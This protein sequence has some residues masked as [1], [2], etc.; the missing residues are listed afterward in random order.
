MTTIKE[1]LHEK[2]KTTEDHIKQ[3]QREGTQGIRYIAMM[4]DIPFLVLGLLSDVGWMIHLIAGI[5]YLSGNGFHHV[6]DYM[7]LIALA[8]VMFGVA[9]IIYL[10]RI[11]EKEIATRRQRNLGFGMTFLS[12]ISGS[13]RR[14]TS[15]RDVYWRFIRACVDSNWRLFE[16]RCGTADLSLVQEGDFLRSKITS[17]FAPLLTNQPY[18]TIMCDVYRTI[19]ITQTISGR[20]DTD[21]GSEE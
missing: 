21:Y 15:D 16:L 8:A 6:L 19:Y 5:I 7:A 10:N 3:L 12:R 11:H 20:K 17:A 18:A 13:R 9:Y 14:N 2:R 4:P 1:T